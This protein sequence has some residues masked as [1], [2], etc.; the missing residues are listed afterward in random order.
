MSRYR[1]FT[2]YYLCGVS[3]LICRRSYAS[4]PCDCPCWRFRPLRGVRPSGEWRPL[5]PTTSEHWVD[6]LNC[7][8]LPPT[9]AW[10]PNEM[11]PCQAFYL[12]KLS[13]PAW[14]DIECWWRLLA[15]W[16]KQP[17]QRR[18]NDVVATL[19]RL[20]LPVQQQWC[21]RSQFTVPDLGHPLGDRRAHKPQI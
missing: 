3:S 15:G 10:L 1:Y 14:H 21:S 12:R 5:S 20:L 4:Y 11:R 18:A 17:V 2:V 16:Q 9:G 13:S 6:G 7:L 19:N 8:V